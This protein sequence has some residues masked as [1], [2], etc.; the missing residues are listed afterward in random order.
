MMY[1]VDFL[2]NSSQCVMHS[3]NLRDGL[4]KV[5]SNADKI[6]GVSY[7]AKEPKRIT[8]ESLKDSWLNDYI[9]SGDYELDRYVSQFLIRLFENDIQVFHGI[10]DTSFVSY[11]AKSE[12]VNFTCY[13]FLKLFTKF[14]DLKMVYALIQGY[15]P[16]YLFA[17]MVQGVEQR[18]NMNISHVWGSG[19]TPLNVPQSSLDILTIEWRSI[20]N[21]FVT[22]NGEI[23][24]EAGFKLNSI[25]VPE[26]RI[27]IYKYH[28]QYDQTQCKVYARKYRF[29]NHICWVQVT[30]DDVDEKTD[31]YDNDDMASLETERL[32]MSSA[33]YEDS[34]WIDNNQLDYDGRSYNFTINPEDIPENSI[35][36]VTETKSVQFTGNAIPYHIYPKGF[37]E[38]GGKDAERL[39]VLK[40][41]LMLHNLTIYSDWTGTIRMVN[42]AIGSGD[43]IVIDPSDVVDFKRKRLNRSVP[44]VS[45]L[46][47]LLGDLTILKDIVSDNYEDFFSQTWEITAVIDNLA[48]YALLLFTI[49]QIKGV[50]YRITELQRD[51]KEDE[52][53]VKAWE[54]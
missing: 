24:V 9:L 35:D 39:K 8:F 2:D 28:H 32:E 43:C 7:F 29:Y 54:L 21:K 11:T 26:L 38:G 42:K 30:S 4:D 50:Q 36:V 37:Y 1:R 22:W 25:Y 33:Y 13:D 12:S 3:I 5:K 53:N 15:H 45:V 40:A 16:G 47:C 6:A 51:P 46:D 27:L 14:S 19:W 20:M 52:Y 49:I 17:Y 23:Y 10:I 31:A 41:A 44:D 48:K 18:L 34:S